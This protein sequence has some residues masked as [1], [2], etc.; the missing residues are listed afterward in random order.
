VLFENA[1]HCVHD[2]LTTCQRGAFSHAGIRS[3]CVDR[4]PGRGQ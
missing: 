2:L 4:S 3:V 1:A